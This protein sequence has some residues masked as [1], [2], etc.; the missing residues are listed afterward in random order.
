MGKFDI[1]EELEKFEVNGAVNQE[2]RK[3]FEQPKEK[4]PE[5]ATAL[6]SM[7]KAEK[8]YF[9]EVAYEHGLNLSSLIRLAT[10]EYIRRNEWDA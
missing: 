3:K 6:I 2:P 9:S 7:T 5:R 1:A 4:R 8:E 10:G